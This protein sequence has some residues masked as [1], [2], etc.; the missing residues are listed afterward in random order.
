VAVAWLPKAKMSAMVHRIELAVSN[1]SGMHCVR[2][3]G[4]RFVCGAI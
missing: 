2:R 4:A 1:A 3:I